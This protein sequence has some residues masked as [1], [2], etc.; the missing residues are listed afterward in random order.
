VRR[1]EPQL[2][3]VTGG[4]T[5]KVTGTQFIPG[6]QI[7]LQVMEDTPT[8][9]F[10]EINSTYVNAEE[11]SFVLPPAISGVGVVNVFL[12][13]NG[14]EY[15][16]D[17]LSF[18]YIAVPEPA[19]VGLIAGL[20]SAAAIV[21]LGAAGALIF[22]KSRKVGLFYEFKLVEPDYALVAFGTLLTPQW[23]CPKDNYDILAQKLL[24]K[25][26][27]FLL[28]VIAIT[29][30]TEQDP[31]ARSLAF[32]YEWHKKCVYSLKLLVHV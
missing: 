31:V 27:S 11:I 18:N 2:G 15:L 9:R 26:T 4:E 29:A 7:R 32:F 3:Y 22:M 17:D 16:E 12:Y 8:P 19:P 10:T 5:I 6:I 1:L 23:R 13:Y 28:S 30:S 21:A 25:D 20:S 14:R 24:S